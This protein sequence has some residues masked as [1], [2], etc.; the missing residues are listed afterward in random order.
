M[1]IVAGIQDVSGIVGDECYPAFALAYSNL[2]TF[3]RKAA[4]KFADILVL[5]RD[6]RK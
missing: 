3:L 1:R 4:C 2:G 6:Q 5:T